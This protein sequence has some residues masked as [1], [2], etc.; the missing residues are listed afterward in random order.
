MSCV[1]DEVFRGYCGVTV[2]FDYVFHRNA[3]F[4]AHILCIFQFFFFNNFVLTTYNQIKFVTSCWQGNGHYFILGLGTFNVFIV[5]RL[6]CK[7]L[8]CMH[9]ITWRAPMT[10]GSM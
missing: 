3:V 6:S 2:F 10:E 5:C 9:Y 7:V 4:F 8:I 1:N